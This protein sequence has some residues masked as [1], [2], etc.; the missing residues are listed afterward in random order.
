MSDVTAEKFGG[1]DS[2]L[3][4]ALGRF[5][6]RVVLL[7]PPR[8]GSTLV[9]RLLWQLPELTHHCHE[10]FEA[11]HWGGAGF[12]SVADNLCHPMALATGERVAGESVEGGGGLLI[13]DMTFQLG[14]GDATLLAR[15]ATTPVIL[16]IR[17]PRLSTTSR[18][19]IVK[20]LCGSDTF[21]PHE[22]GWPALAEH[23]QL[24]RSLAIPYVIVESDQL[25]SHPGEVLPALA[26]RLPLSSWPENPSWEPR[27]GLR[28]CA[29]EVS[30][31]M[32]ARPADD[33]PFYRRVLD[34]TGI[35]PV[36]DVDWAREEHR[37]AEAGL[38]EHVAEWRHAYRLL[39]EDDHLVTGPL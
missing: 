29:P 38:T 14:S 7:S 20:E 11:A 12:D 16:V 3:R 28:L 27:P 31:L 15:L 5:P 24:F 17:D 19:R 30:K 36:D 6:T 8:T 39:L 34:S 9:A 2:R 32:G 35:Q 13:K 25:R 4:G 22:S 18:L 21:A 33:D 26:A 10:P 23:V 1:L 37:I